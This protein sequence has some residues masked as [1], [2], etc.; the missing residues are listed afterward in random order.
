MKI[1]LSFLPSVA[2]A[3]G[4]ASA[5]VASAQPAADA[6]SA[7]LIVGVYNQADPVSLQKAQWLWG[8]R[9]YCWYP[10]GWH[11]P[12]YYWCGYASRRGIGW[13]G[14]AGWHGWRYDQGVRGDRGWRGDRGDRGLHRGW[15]HRGQGRDHRD[16]NYR[17]NNYRDNNY[18]DNNYPR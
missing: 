12:G 1:R 9:N 7:H 15:D 14:P 5:G 11:G 17:D 8:G 6:P 18:R 16:N 2:A 3:I 4:L 10:G 13:G